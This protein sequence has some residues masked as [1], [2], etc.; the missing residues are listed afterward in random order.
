MVVDVGDGSRKSTLET[1][2]GARVIRA[3]H[4]D[5]GKVSRARE[6]FVSS[7]ELHPRDKEL[8]TPRHDIAIHA[9]HFVPE[10]AKNSSQRDLG[11]D[12]VS[13]GTRVPD[14]RHLAPAY[15]LDEPRELR[16]EFGIEFFHAAK[17]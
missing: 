17:G 14:D 5:R 2:A 15:A 11:P 10:D 1:I 9:H 7:H 8:Q 3:V 13:I 4:E 12:A 16:R 6:D